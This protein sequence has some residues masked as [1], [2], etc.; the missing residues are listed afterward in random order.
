LIPAT[1][2][3]YVVSFEFYVMSTAY[4]LLKY[5][6]IDHLTLNL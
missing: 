1:V 2:V 3:L 6:L 4:I 5:L